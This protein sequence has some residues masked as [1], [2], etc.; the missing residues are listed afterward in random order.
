[1]ERD[2]RRLA[3]L[4]QTTKPLQVQGLRRSGARGT[5]TPD[6]LGAIQA[7]KLVDFGYLA[8]IPAPVRALRAAEKYAHFAGF[9]TGSITR[10]G[11]RDETRT[12]RDPSARGLE[13][14]DDRGHRVLVDAVSLADRRGAPTASVPVSL[15]SRS[16][17]VAGP[18]I[19]AVTPSAEDAQKH[20]ADHAAAHDDHD[21]NHQ[22]DDQGATVHH[23]YMRTRFD[24]DAPIRR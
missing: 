24:E 12:G 19:A 20:A 7:A 13:R 18:M 10:S 15:A 22:N 14:P 9:L 3:A 23:R 8:G 6:L 1:M 4:P 16:S 17:Y 21:D 5:R 11:P 2:H